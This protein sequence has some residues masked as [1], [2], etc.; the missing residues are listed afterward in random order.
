MHSELPIWCNPL[1]VGR[2]KEAARA[3]FV[4]FA[5]AASALAA[6]AEPWLDWTKSPFVQCLDGEWAF[7]WSPNPASAPDGFADPGFD[8]AGWDRIPVPSCWQ[9]LGDE[10][11]HG[12]PKYDVPI[13]TNVRY[14]FPIDNLPAVP[15]D[16]N[17]TGCYRRD[18]TVPA[19]WDGC[20]VFLHFEGVDSA[21]TV[22]VNGHEVGYSQES[23]V[24]AEFN[25]TPYLQPGEN[26][27]AVQ[28]LRWSDGSYLEDQDFWRLSGI[29][30]SVWL[31]AAPPVHVRDFR[32]RTEMDADYASA[33][34]VVEAEVR[35]LGA[36]ADRGYSLEAQ[37]Y[38]SDGR[39]VF[40][41]P[42]RQT[43][44]VGAGHATSVEL[45][46]WVES[47]AKWSDETP[48]LYTVLVTLRDAAGA[49]TQVVGC[50]IGFR[51]VEIKQGQIHVN[52]VP[53]LLKGANRHE[54]NPSTGH[55]ITV[56]SMITDIVLMKQHNLNAVRTSHYPNNPRWYDLCDYYG[57]WVFDEANLETH[58]V[59]DRLTKDPLWETAFLDRAV[60][61]VGRDKNHPSIIVWSLGNESGYGRNHDVMANWIRAHDPTRPL[62][63]H[64][65]EDGPA[66][67]ILAPMY[68][69]VARIIEM[70]QDPRETRP[71]IMCEYA[72]S[73]GNSTGNL[74]EYW[75]AIA[76]YP[77]LQGGFIWDWVDQGILQ[78]SAAGEFYYAYGG[79]FGDEP[80]DG[81]F[82]GN[83]LLGSDR[84]PHPALLE[85]KKVLE[86]VRVMLLDSAT[87]VIAVENRH[88]T[89][90]LSA[91]T[92]TWEIQ[93]IGAVA[94]TTG[95]ATVRV[96]WSGV[97]A[98]LHTPA[99]GRTQV[100]LP[101]GD[102]RRAGDG[103]AWLVVRVSRTTATIWSAA[104][105][106]VA[107]AQF[108]LATAPRPAARG[109]GP[110]VQVSEDASA[111]EF[112]RDGLRVAIDKGSGQ[113]AS[114]E[115]SGLALVEQGPALQVWRAPT[116][117]DANTWGDQRAAIRWREVGLDRVE[118]QIDGVMV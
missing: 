4:P 100:Q 116:D 63:Y 88:H 51:Q 39:A 85:Y 97:L 54:H 99:G 112:A 43:A 105:H 17:P 61:M 118:D 52:G 13:Y 91:Y 90:D 60:R 84:S 113:L 111:I 92:I 15:Q 41:E 18:F 59:W 82:C 56:D 83:G 3:T 75:D 89:S 14:P 53:I 98:P 42:L 77:R 71:I 21:C 57:L 109:D 93:E 5:D 108:P 66:T 73:M 117:N 19:A 78:Q 95:E 45:S 6:Y 48:N 40:G 62:H 107:W 28:V 30:R 22:W 32:V 47:P 12:K 35:N 58:G 2:N 86:P 29:Y 16:D 8:V 9:M 31:W 102:W 49:A 110:A 25:I 34:L 96:A 38:G 7:A 37:L 44:E 87:G 80:N 104:G 20:Q 36:T 76:T 68:P 24:P 65:A 50:R 69:S 55:T 64:P 103:D 33:T 72:H 11:L 23:R 10:F 1:V 81:N 46:R 114:F 101:W 27:L 26:I 106:P 79:D 67:D 94:T 74:K 115:Q 70:A